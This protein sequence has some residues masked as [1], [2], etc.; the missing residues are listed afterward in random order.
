MKTIKETRSLKIDYK[1]FTGDDII[2]LSKLFLKLTNEI[3]DKS[4]EIRRKELIMKEH[5]DAFIDEMINDLGHF[6][7]EITSSDNSRYSGPLEDIMDKGG[8]LENKKITEISLYFAE[9]VFNSSI[10]IRI[11][12]SEYDSSYVVIEGK[13]RTWVNGTTR[14]FEDF[15]SDCKNQPKIVKKLQ[16][17]IILFSIIFF[18]LLLLNLIELIVN[19]ILIIS[20]SKID[21]FSI[22]GDWNAIL[23]FLGISLIT[24]FPSISIYQWI[25]ELWPKI[26]IQTGKDFQNIEKVKRKKL[27]VILSIIII[28]SIISFLF[29][30]F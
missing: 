24:M 10:L 2:T 5:R 15:L 9:P 16:W 17:L 21:H 22:Y 29:R 30:I 3:L 8:I 4:K 20:R 25:E 28:P 27:W 7:V 6:N 1:V 26:E 18:N 11:R 13:D 19:K 23:F 14:I 12:H